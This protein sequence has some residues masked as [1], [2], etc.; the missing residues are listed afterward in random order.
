MR[1]LRSSMRNKGLSGFKFI[2]LLALTLLLA[3]CFSPEDFE[4]RAVSISNLTS[5]GTDQTELGVDLVLYNPNGYGDFHLGSN[6]V[7][8]FTQWYGANLTT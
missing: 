3:G 2:G 6:Q 5:L 4:V 1:V 7:S 8:T